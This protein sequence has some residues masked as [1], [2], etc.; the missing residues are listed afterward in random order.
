MHTSK[1]DEVCV[2]I[3]ITLLNLKI[4]L[5]TSRLEL[6]REGNET[7]GALLR[8]KRQIDSYDPYETKPNKTRCPL[9]LVADYRFFQE[10][11]GSDT[12]TTINYLV[13]IFVQFSYI[14]FSNHITIEPS[15]YRSAWSIEFIKFTTIQRGKTDKNLTDS[16][17]WVSSSRK[18]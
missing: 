8:S 15:I 11:G 9:L 10:M 12:K 13:R 16:T 5:T 4:F 3:L 1:K 18:Y 7:L 2:L 6:E 17:E 14:R